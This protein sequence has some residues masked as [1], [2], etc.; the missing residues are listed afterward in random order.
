LATPQPVTV[1]C[2]I[3]LLLPMFY[4]FLASPAFLF[5]RL[6]IPQVARLL[7]AMFYGYF[8]ALI[9]AGLAGSMLVALDRHALPA[10]ALASVAAIA[11]A[12]RRW[13]M[14]RLEILLQERDAGVAGVAGRLRWLH[15]TGMLVNAMQLLAV[16]A[17][18]PSLVMMA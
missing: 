11:F 10:L 4:L 15:V 18:V 9:V 5:V 7:R 8:V 13:F 6:D 14:A 12:W 2:V 3:V 17:S 1:F 16:I